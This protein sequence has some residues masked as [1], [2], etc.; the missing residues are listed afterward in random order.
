MCCLIP[1]ENHCFRDRKFLQ[2][3]KHSTY[4]SGLQIHRLHTEVGSAS[5]K[6][7]DEPIAHHPWHTC[8]FST[9]VFRRSP[10]CDNWMS[11]QKILARTRSLSSRF[12][13]VACR[14]K[15]R[16][17]GASSTSLPFWAYFLCPGTAEYANC[18]LVSFMLS[19]CLESSW[20]LLCWGVVLCN[21]APWKPRTCTSAVAGAGT[22]CWL[23]CAQRIGGFLVGSRRTS[24]RQT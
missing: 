19:F 9:I 16:V 13:V 7:I 11:S 15:C 24:H 1:K 14:R 4:L 21:T 12:I 6:A 18:S 5:Q 17:C 2:T 23:G 3:S 22:V 20:R 8:I 10:T